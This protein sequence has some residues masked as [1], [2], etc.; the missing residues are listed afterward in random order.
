MR[1]SAASAC[2]VRWALAEGRAL[3]I[4]ASINT[5]REFFESRTQPASLEE[6][7]PVPNVTAQN[8]P[9]RTPEALNRESR[10]RKSFTVR[11][12]RRLLI[13]G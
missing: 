1:S 13:I 3:T 9:E 4:T 5:D 2:V 7:V 12:S 10:R 8:W 11:G 6:L